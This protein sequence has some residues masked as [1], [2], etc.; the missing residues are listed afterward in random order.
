MCKEDAQGYQEQLQVLAQKRGNVASAFR[1][2]PAIALANDVPH[3]KQ[4]WKLQNVVKESNVKEAGNGRY[5]L[6]PLKKGQVVVQK[7]LVPMGTVTSLATLPLDGTLTFNCEADCEKYIALA[8]KEGGYSREEVLKVFE[9]FMYGFDGVT[10]CL[11]V[12]SWTI[13]HA[14]E[15]FKHPTP[16]NM[17]VEERS[18]GWF[19]R[20]KTYAAVAASDIAAGEEMHIDYRRFKLPAF[21]TNFCRTQKVPYGDVRAET[22]KAVYGGD[23]AVKTGVSPV[24]WKSA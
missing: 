7:V 17:C 11:N 15:S 20:E 4:G 1:L 19:R 6:E 18:R 14:D 12:T 16:L 23:D 2:P 10:S 24:Q 13:N 5:A 21:Y 9:H 22:L 8:E 3:L